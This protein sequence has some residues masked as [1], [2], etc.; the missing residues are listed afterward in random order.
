M[1]AQDKI[2]QARA[3]IEP[4]KDFTPGPW[5]TD[6][7]YS[8]DQLGIAILAA[9][10][11]CG[12]LPGNPTRGM[13][14]WASQILPEDIGRCEADAR[15]IVA[16]P[17]MRDTIAALADLAEAESARADKAKAEAASA[18]D[19]ST[20]RALEIIMSRI[21]LDRETQRIMRVH[22]HNSREDLARNNPEDTA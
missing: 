7:E 21:K 13:V 8:E 16:A 5:W 12:P 4:L 2:A 14:A 9:R 11:D 10:T 3:L 22:L 1:T 15:L 19:M 18:N 17:D 20:A 6:G